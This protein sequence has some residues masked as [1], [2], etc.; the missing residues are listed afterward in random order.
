MPA[1]R[2]SHSDRQRSRHEA[3]QK[4]VMI[5]GYPILLPTGIMGRRGVGGDDP[6]VRV[7][8]HGGGQSR[9]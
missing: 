7:C 6:I 5:I 1:T 9:P 2:P 3:R 8:R 4:G